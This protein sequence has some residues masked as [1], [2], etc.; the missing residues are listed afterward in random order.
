MKCDNA[1][2]FHRKSGVAQWRDLLFFLRSIQFEWKRCPL[3][4]HPERSRGT[5]GSADLSW[6]CGILFS[7][8]RAWSGACEESAFGIKFPR[9]NSKLRMTEAVSTLRHGIGRIA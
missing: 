2:K 8:R 7:T 5:C 6:K 9:Q 3:P 4:C 1:T